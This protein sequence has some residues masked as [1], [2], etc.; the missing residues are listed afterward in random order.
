MSVK[1][2]GGHTRREEKQR[3][4]RDF[5]QDCF[6]ITLDPGNRV[7]AMGDQIG[8][9]TLGPGVEISP[10]KTYFSSLFE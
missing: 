3:R 2:L 5:S 10:V 1:S 4:V 7:L 9:K 6:S 8:Q